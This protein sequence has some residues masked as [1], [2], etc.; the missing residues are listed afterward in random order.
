[1]TNTAENQF[2]GG[3]TREKLE[4]LRGYLNAYTTAL[5]RQPFKL[6]YIDA[7][8]GTGRVEPRNQDP[9][10][11]DRRAFIDGSA[12]IAL[13][14]EDKSFDE[15]IFIEKDEVKCSKLERLKTEK[16]GRNIVI[17]TADA[18]NF[19]QVLQKDWQKWRGALFLDPF[20]AQVDWSTLEAIAGYR[21]LDTWILFPT[22]TI[23]RMLPR[24]RTPD[25]ISPKWARTLTRVYGDER[26]RDLYDEDPQGELFPEVINGSQLR[27][28]SGVDKLIKIYKERL[29]ELFGRRFLDQSRTLKNSRNSPMYEFMFC[30]G[31]DGRAAIRL[32]KEIADYLLDPMNEQ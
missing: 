31:N 26:W 30:V 14:I 2:G 21:A 7:F 29:E 13:D 6:L 15:L 4:I 17:E 10:Q 19:L 5:K 3:W 8:A 27:R 1:M 23:A 24:S 18:N 16:P 25:D 32:A 28:E 12:K 9:D 20:G 11:E 22:G